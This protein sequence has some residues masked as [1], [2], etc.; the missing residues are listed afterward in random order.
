MTK[1]ICKT[2]MAVYQRTFNMHADELIIILKKSRVQYNPA[3]RFRGVPRQ[4]RWVMFKK[5]N[6]LQL[7][8]WDLE[9]P[10]PPKQTAE[11]ID[12]GDNCSLILRM[13]TPV[14][15]ILAWAGMVSLILYQCIIHQTYVPLLFV[16]PFLVAVYFLARLARR[17]FKNAIF[18]AIDERTSTYEYK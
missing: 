14:F 6:M 17:D 7:V 5:P 9:Y 15:I 4:F 1:R 11:I 3:G 10:G 13:K 16:T 18:D 12:K 8:D 2:G